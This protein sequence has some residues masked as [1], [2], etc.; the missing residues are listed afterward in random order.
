MLPSG[1]VTLPAVPASV[2]T[3]AKNA[4]RIDLPLTAKALAPAGKT[5][6]VDL[7]PLSGPSKTIL[8]TDTVDGAL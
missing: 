2:V 6:R 3:D 5:Y 1:T 4:V 8:G 7:L